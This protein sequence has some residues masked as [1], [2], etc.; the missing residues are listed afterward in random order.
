V[1]NDVYTLYELSKLR[2][3]DL[4]AAADADRLADLLPLQARPVFSVRLPDIS[5]ALL[6]RPA[7]PRLAI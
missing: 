5:A 4:R 2:Q 3:G 6:H 7:S 1:T